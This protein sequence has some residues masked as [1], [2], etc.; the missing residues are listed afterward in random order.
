MINEDK[1]INSLNR[2]SSKFIEN[3]NHLD[4]DKWINTI[5]K[6]KI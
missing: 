2:K 4:H 6:K 5:P 3:A 1:W